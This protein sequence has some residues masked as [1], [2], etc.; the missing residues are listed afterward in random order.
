MDNAKKTKQTP[1]SKSE[2]VEILNNK[3]QKAKY[4][5]PTAISLVVGVVIGSGIFLKNADVIQNTHSVLLTFLSW[6]IGGIGIL[7]AALALIEIISAKNKDHKDGIISWSNTIVNKKFANV[8]AWF[9]MIIYMPIIYATLAVYAAHFTAKLTNYG[10]TNWLFQFGLAAAFFSYFLIINSFWNKPGRL[11]Q[12]CLTIFKLI[13]LMMI[14]LFGIFSKSSA[15]IFDPVSNAKGAELH[16]SIIG[17]LFALPAILFAFDG[18]YYVANTK[19]EMKNPDKNLPKAI[20]IGIVFAIVFYS[21]FSIAI[22]SISDPSLRNIDHGAGGVN[23]Y[24]PTAFMPWFAKF[25]DCTVIIATL[26]GL[27]GYSIVGARIIKSCGARFKF[28]FSHKIQK[29]SKSGAPLGAGVFGFVLGF[30]VIVIAL[31]LGFAYAA[32]NNSHPDNNHMYKVDGFVKIIDFLSNWETI[33]ELLLMSVILGYGILNRFNKKVE[34][35]KKWYFI[36]TAII[37][38]IF[39]VV[40]LGSNVIQ[41]AYLAWGPPH[42][43]EKEI[44]M[45]ILFAFLIIMIF[46]LFIKNSDKYKEIKNKNKK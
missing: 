8:V 7:C 35:D 36:P 28:K 22:F 2:E 10:E 41:T 11:F 45:Y 44:L 15:H 4:G 1:V 17:I 16:G 12:L 13:P 30:F 39:F 38:I 25:I 23:N 31:L 29:E 42:K 37:A 3:K 14:V 19:D 27:N 33:I 40:V 5:L 6:V 9:F 32:A 34:V 18:F 26:V 46:G 21:L 24:T 43:H 20:M